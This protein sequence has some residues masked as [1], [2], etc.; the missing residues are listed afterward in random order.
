MLHSLLKVD[1]VMH[2]YFA[3]LVSTFHIC[4]WCVVFFYYYFCAYFHSHE[5][6]HIEQ[7]ILHRPILHFTSLLQQH[8][9]YG[10]DTCNAGLIQ[11]Q[12]P[13]RSSQTNFIQIM[14]N[15]LIPYR[16]TSTH[17]WMHEKAQLVSINYIPT[18]TYSN[19]SLIWKLFSS[20]VDNFG[21]NI[22]QT[23]DTNSLTYELSLNAPRALQFTVKCK[24]LKKTSILINVEMFHFFFQILIA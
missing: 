10:L 15:S 21:Q 17:T 9:P 5:N 13:T 1:V 4:T 6:I 22:K 12:Q 24:I 3:T 23:V 2:I 18:R 19:S 14:I 20:L 8:S 11:A 16:C 7:T